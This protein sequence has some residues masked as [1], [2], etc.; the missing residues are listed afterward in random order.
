MGETLTGLFL[1]AIG[2][3]FIAELGD[4]SQFLALGLAAKY[5]PWKVAVGLLLST[6]TT[7]LLAVLV[8]TAVGSFID[9]TIMA[10]ASGALF[11]GFGLWTLFGSEDDDGEG[12]E[13]TP[14]K[15]GPILATYLT[16]FVAEFGDK[17]QLLALALAADASPAALGVSTW[18][19]IAVVVA[20]AT[21][22]MVASSGVAIIVGSVLGKAIPARAVRYLS[23]GVF[24]VVGAL[25]LLDAILG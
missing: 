19:V 14:S 13:A 4:K 8:G 24:M 15:Y 23:A 16:F 1:T 22:G 6:L 5:R 21:I 7:M 12:G 3:M 25:T 17:T 9:P 18:Q 10:Y 20:G 2:M 11:I